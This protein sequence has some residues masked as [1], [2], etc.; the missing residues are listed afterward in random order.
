MNLLLS[1]LALRRGV[2]RLLV[3]ATCLLP[4]QAR[5]GFNVF[6]KID[7]ITGESTDTDHPG[8]IQLKST[9]FQD[10]INIVQGGAQVAGAVRPDFSNLAVT[11]DTQLSSTQ[12][13][14]ACASKKQF[15]SATIS[16]QPPGSGRR[17]IFI[18]QLENVRIAS[19]QLSANDEAM[20]RF[21]LGYTA[22]TIT[23][24]P[25]RPDGT[26]SST[27]IEQRFDLVKNR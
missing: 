15:P 25:T 4:V 23:Y 9:S 6:L 7:G 17:I 2:L 13:L 24:Y 14:K 21:T 1:R 10:V 20:D 3:V 18:L 5:A 19:Y 8:E 22:I 16:F 12:L 11:C 26:I 27:P